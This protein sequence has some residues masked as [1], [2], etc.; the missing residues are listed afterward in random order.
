MRWDRSKQQASEASQLAS[1]SSQG[2]AQ[3]RAETD[4]VAAA[5]NQMAAATQ[6]VSGNVQSTADATHE[7]SELSL[8][9]KTVA[10]RARQAM[11][12][13]SGAVN[14]ATTITNQLA[15]D[16]REIGSVVDV[17]K[18]IAEQTNLL[19]LNAAIEAARAGEQGRGFAVVADEVRALASRTAES[20]E[21]IHNLI[22]NLQQA[23][24]S[25]VDSMRSGNEQAERGVQQVSEADDALE[26][27]RQAIER[28]NEMASQIASAAEE[29]SSVA[30][31]INRNVSNIANLADNTSRDA[32]RSAALSNELTATAEAQVNLVER[33][34]RR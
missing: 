33:F 32:Q 19:A 24:Q 5:I 7:A 31:E 18:G 29:Q 25:T 1:Q 30:E 12:S 23:A 13:L 15:N 21:Q 6:E 17:I 22:A 28:I 8:H 20:T 3:Q 14:S 10:T 4:Q 11:E 34:N 9:G 16:A 2:L 27:I 26:G